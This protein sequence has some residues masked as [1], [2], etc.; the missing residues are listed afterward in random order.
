MS[1]TRSTASDRRIAANREG[2]AEASQAQLDKLH[3][4]NA[5]K[6]ED[7]PPESK[8]RKSAPEDKS[9]GS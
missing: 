6:A 9:G 2:E 4:R 1:P 8:A 5:S 7:A 3:T